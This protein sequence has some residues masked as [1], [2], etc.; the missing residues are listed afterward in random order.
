M[1]FNDDTLNISALQAANGSLQDALDNTILK[2]TRSPVG[3]V[4]PSSASPFQPQTTNNHVQQHPPQ[5]YAQHPAK[6]ISKMSRFPESHH[7]HLH[8]LGFNTNQENENALLISNGNLEQA[9]EILLEWRGKKQPATISGS[10]QKNETKPDIFGDY[11]AT[12]NEFGAFHGVTATKELPSLGQ[13]SNIVND[14]VISDPFASFNVKASVRDNIKAPENLMG[15]FAGM[16]DLNFS[17]PVVLSA[18]Q[19]S[20]VNSIKA[21]MGQPTPAMF[22]QQSWGVPPNQMNYGQFG[23]QNM[24]NNQFPPNQASQFNQQSNQGLPMFGQ[25]AVVQAQNQTNVA[26]GAAISLQT[27]TQNQAQFGSVT[28]PLQYGQAQFENGAF[29]QQQFGGQTRF[30]SAMQPAQQEIVFFLFITDTN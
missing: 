17:V 4:F 7:S 14:S 30:R 3:N 21:L 11:P 16:T 5:Q 15:D 10:G 9:L 1:G 20:K 13:K 22:Q 2:T 27:T 8:S 23:Q 28:N 25:I 26:Y 12:T 19:D 24:M 18:M 29:S 6:Q